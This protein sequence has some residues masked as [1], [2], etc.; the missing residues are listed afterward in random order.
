[1]TTIVSWNTYELLQWTRIRM[2]SCMMMFV[3][4][5]SISNSL[6]FIFAWVATTGLR[7]VIKI[8]W[9][10]ASLFSRFRNDPGCIWTHSRGQTLSNTAANPWVDALGSLAEW[11]FELWNVPLGGPSV[12]LDFEHWVCSHHPRYHPVHP[13]CLVLEKPKRTWKWTLHATNIN[14][15]ILSGL[16][17]TILYPTILDNSILYYTILQCTIPYYDALPWYLAYRHHKQDLHLCIVTYL[18]NNL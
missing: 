2:V 3:N 16:Y 7:C 5:T 6:G 14:N 12:F 10:R 15:E 18:N 17:Y 1:M 13:Q 4:P 8:E 9:C 11:L